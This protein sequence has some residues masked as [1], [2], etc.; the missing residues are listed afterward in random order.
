MRFQG[1]S[2]RSSFSVF[3][4]DSILIQTGSNRAAGFDDKALR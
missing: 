4:L 2:Q 1:L 3:F